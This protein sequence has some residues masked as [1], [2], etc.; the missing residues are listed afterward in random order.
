LLEEKCKPPLGYFVVEF[1]LGDVPFFDEVPNVADDHP[2]VGWLFLDV[3]Y[4][5]EFLGTEPL[6]RGGD[7]H[8]TGNGCQKVSSKSKS[9]G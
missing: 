9:A 7:E 6:G 4:A 1:R 5:R 2:V 3:G 8:R